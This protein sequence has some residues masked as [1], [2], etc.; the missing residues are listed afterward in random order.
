[1]SIENIT[2]AAHLERH[3]ICLRVES[4]EY[5]CYCSDCCPTSSLS[6]QSDM[7]DSRKLD[8][9]E[10]LINLWYSKTNDLGRKYIKG[11]V[12]R[13]LDTINISLYEFKSFLYIIKLTGPCNFFKRK[14]IFDNIRSNM[15]PSETPASVLITWKRFNIIMIAWNYLNQSYF[16][17]SKAMFEELQPF[18]QVEAHIIRKFESYYGLKLKRIKVENS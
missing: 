9:S 7:L 18:Y 6:E 4:Y 5:I 17:N 3:D 16:R 12:K 1:M 8:K 15:N 11:W 10:E 13:G 2:I 14:E